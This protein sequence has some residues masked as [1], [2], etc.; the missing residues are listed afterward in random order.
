MGEQQLQEKQFDLL[1]TELRRIGDQLEAVQHSLALLEALGQ[2][3]PEHLV[4]RSFL[5]E[6][7]AEDQRA[8]ARGQRLAESMLAAE[9]NAEM[10]ECLDIVGLQCQRLL[11]GVDRAHPVA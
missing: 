10:T 4:G 2:E 1:L 6:L 3:I 5:P 7:R 9:R 11:E 8:P